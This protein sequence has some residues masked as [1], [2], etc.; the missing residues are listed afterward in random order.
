[1]STAALAVLTWDGGWTDA[2]VRVAQL[3]DHAAPRG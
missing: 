1:M 3:R 2:D